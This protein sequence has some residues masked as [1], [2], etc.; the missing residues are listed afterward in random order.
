MYARV[1]TI[2]GL[3]DKMDDAT[4]HVQ[5]QTLPQLQKMDGFKGFAALADRQSGKLLGV[6]FWE[7]EEALRATEEAVSS[8]RSGAAEAASGTVAG[9]EQ[10]EV[11]VFEAP[12]SGPVSAVT[13]TVGGVTDTVGG[14]TKP[15]SGVTD[16]VGGATDTVRGATD[17]L[18]GGGG[19]E[20]QR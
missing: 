11:V 10:Y 8:V 3:P 15:V 14:A 9:V 19:G 12:S 7:D 2:E 20:K 1:T 4:R 6:A 13:D 16:T 18:L 17:K 5:E